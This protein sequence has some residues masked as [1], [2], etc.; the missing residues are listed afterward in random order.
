MKNGCNELGNSYCYIHPRDVVVGV[1][2]LCLNERL[3]I[4][5]ASSSQGRCRSSSRFNNSSAFH[6]PHHQNDNYLKNHKNN[7]NNNNKN[8]P[9]A[10]GFH[11]IF[12]FGSLLHRLEFRP[13]KPD[14][15]ADDDVHD[16]STSQ[17]GMYYITCFYISLFCIKKS[18]RSML[19]C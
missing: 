13:S 15:S 17:E 19:A 6:K 4:L 10:L 1:C 14:F 16:V 12:D 11:K 18:K 2:P 3:L 7:N 9:H 5:A 8:K